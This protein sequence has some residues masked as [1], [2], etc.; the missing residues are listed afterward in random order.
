MKV[1]SFICIGGILV[2]NTSN[3]RTGIKF[4]LAAGTVNKID[5]FIFIFKFKTN[6]IQILKK[7]KYKLPFF[8]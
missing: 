5:I 8:D 6:L 1:M 3:T 7:D 4:P 2:C